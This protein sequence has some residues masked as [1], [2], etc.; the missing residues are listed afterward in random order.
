M[1]ILDRVP[2]DAKLRRIFTQETFGPR[3]H[4]PRC[5]T[6]HIRRSEH[7]YRC[8]T[9][10]KPFSL[11]SASW[12]KGTKLN[13][14]QLWLLIDCWQRKIAFHT[15]AQITGVSTVTVR[16]WFRRFQEQLVYE[17][18][19]L[20]GTI[21]MDEAFL[22]KRRHGNQRIVLGA[23]ERGSKHIVLRMTRNRDQGT[24]DEFLLRHVDRQ[25][26]VWTDG[27]MCYEGIT[28]FFGYLHG[29]CNHG[30]W[31]FGP[32]NHIENVWS[33]LKGFIR[34]T[35]HHFHKEWLPMLLREFEARWNTPELFL[36]PLFYLRT[37][38]V[39]VPTC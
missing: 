14:K 38:L 24:T 37:C 36:S 17:S 25:S 4:C 33:A 10:R 29:T 13:L 18:P 6:S 28:E 8:R 2:K 3:V 39:A 35:Y 34:R 31:E 1:N 15:T 30:I 5:G 20:G 7:R 11:K 21:E 23:Y 22:G 19:D 27:A 9:C 26:M 16:R 32:T 12:L